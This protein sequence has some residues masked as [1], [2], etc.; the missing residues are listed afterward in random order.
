MKGSIAM[1]N[2]LLLGDSI[3]MLY[4]PLVKEKLKDKDY[5]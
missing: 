5:V 2:I 4:Q 1:K 3:R